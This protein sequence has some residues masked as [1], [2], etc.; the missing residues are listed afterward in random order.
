[1]KPRKPLEDLRELPDEITKAVSKAS[2]ICALYGVRISVTLTLM[3]PDWPSKNI[4]T[5]AAPR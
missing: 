5:K 4:S 3:G 1:M 2:D